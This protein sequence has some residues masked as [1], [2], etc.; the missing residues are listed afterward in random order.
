MC[1]VLIIEDEVLIA[2]DIQGMLSESGASSFAF[3]STEAEAVDEAR[4]HRPEFISSDVCLQEGYGSNAVATIHRELGYIPTVYVTATPDSCHG[5][6]PEHVL[7][8]PLREA[9]IVALF[10]ELAP[11]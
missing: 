8:K 7:G 2:F 3:A 1:H 5:C 4:R 11:I 9:Q 6:P 10:K